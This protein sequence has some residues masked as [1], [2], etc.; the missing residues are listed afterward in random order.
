MQFRRQG[1]S[2]QTELEVME[3]CATSRMPITPTPPGVRESLLGKTVDKILENLG[4]E[5]EL[6]MLDCGSA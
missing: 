5:G 3:P 1:S 6:T 4:V 2:G